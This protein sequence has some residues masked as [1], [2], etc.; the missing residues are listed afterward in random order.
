[1]SGVRAARARRARLCRWRAAGA[2]KK[3]SRQMRDAARRTAPPPRGACR[4]P[5]SLL[6]A[7]HLTEHIDNRVVRE[8][9]A[10]R[11]RGGSEQR[12]AGVCRCRRCVAR[13]WRG[14]GARVGPGASRS[15]AGGRLASPC[16]LSLHRCNAA[17]ANSRQGASV[18]QTLSS[19][20]RSVV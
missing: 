13:A 11:T 1:M 9:A 4:A 6:R 15:E 2:R 5:R 12:A 8:P 10:A 7:T 17:L 18:G 20:R 19:V 14:R 3:A 16:A